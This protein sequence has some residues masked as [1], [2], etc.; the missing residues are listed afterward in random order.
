MIRNLTSALIKLLTEQLAGVTITADRLASAPTGSG[1]PALGIYPGKFVTQQTTREI[2]PA[3]SDSK[4]K[5]T[6]TV[7]CEF[8]QELMVDAYGADESEAEKCASLACNVMLVSAED[9]LRSVNADNPGYDSGLFQSI[10]LPRQLK[11]LEGTPSHA[12]RAWS[13]RL[14][15]NVVGELRLIQKVPE[16]IETPIDEV[17]V[18]LNL[19]GPNP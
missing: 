8:Q 19:V 6:L 2:F 18:T 10:H 14:K 3:T 15:F 16:P 4:S 5:Q 17:S 11:L 9:I 12:D 13:Y 7:K 1:L